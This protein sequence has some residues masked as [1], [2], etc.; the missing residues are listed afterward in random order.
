MLAFSHFNVENPRHQL[1]TTCHYDYIEVR[2]VVNNV[3]FI[4]YMFEFLGKVFFGG[5]IGF[6]MYR[7]FPGVSNFFF[8]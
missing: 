7:F 8:R 3:L 4:C 5:Y 6:F 1:A 2:V